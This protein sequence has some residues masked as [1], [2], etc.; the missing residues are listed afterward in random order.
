MIGLIDVTNESDFAGGVASA[1]DESMKQVANPVMRRFF[2]GMRCLLVKQRMECCPPNRRVDRRLVRSD[3]SKLAKP[4]R[5]FQQKL[6]E[7]RIWEK[8]SS[9]AGDESVAYRF[10]LLG[11]P[12][13]L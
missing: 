6:P 5:Y 12:R 11:W 7:C 3:G 2:I 13:Y 9:V 8:Q 10:A 1:N 4:A